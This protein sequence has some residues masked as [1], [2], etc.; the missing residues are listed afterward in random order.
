MKESFA[1]SPEG[2]VSITCAAAG[3]YKGLTASPAYGAFGGFTLD[4][5]QDA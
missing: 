3:Q 5:G 1:S 2:N 4:T